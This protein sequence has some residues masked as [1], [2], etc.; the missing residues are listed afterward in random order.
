MKK[1]LSLLP[2]RFRWSI[3]N[4]IAH[5]MSEILYLIGL[6]KAS[7]MIHD[8]TIPDHRPEEGRG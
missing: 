8:C 6:E 3:H 1:F 2:P 4:L 7:N 5:P